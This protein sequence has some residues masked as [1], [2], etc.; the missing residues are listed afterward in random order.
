MV[1]VIFKDLNQKVD[2][3]KS[4]AKIIEFIKNNRKT[5]N[6]VSCSLATV[7]GIITIIASGITFGYTVKYSDEVIALVSSQDEYAKADE[8]VVSK[9]DEKTAKETAVSPKFGITLTV[10]DKFNSTQEIVEAI[11]A[12]NDEIVEANALLVNG[13]VKAC[14]LENDFQSILE[15]KRTAHYIDGAENTSEFEESIKVEKGY[16]SKSDIISKEDFK[17]IVDNLKVKTV[18]IVKTRVEVPFETK[19]VKTDKKAIGYT[20]VT[21]KGENGI[22]EKTKKVISVNGKVSS[23]EV[24]SSKVVKEQVSEVVTI[25]TAVNRVAANAKARA[26]S[27]GF[28]CPVSRGQFVVTAYYGDGRNHRG[29]DLGANCGTPI[30]AVAAGTITYAGYDSDFGYNIVIQHSNGLKTRYAHANA[31]CVS[32]GSRVSQG[33][34]IATVGNTGWSTGNHL[35]FEVIVNGNRVNPG[36][37]IGLN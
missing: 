36:P 22:T 2:L 33:D 29:I 30:F 18:S 5:V 27:A 21:T 23:S 37:Y 14:F 8:I 28:I 35:H 26:A 4:L 10:S 6:I 24:I 17:K 11:I 12:N 3:K 1:T 32:K 31:L 9:L 20:K 13:E 34:M 25:G 7:A 16:Y 15:E 19:N